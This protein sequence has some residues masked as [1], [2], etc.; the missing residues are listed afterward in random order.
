MLGAQI[1]TT[2]AATFVAWAA[3][4]RS[5][6]IAALFGGIVAVVPTAWFAIKT[7]PRPG[8]FKPVEILGATYRA[9]VGKLVLTASLFWIGAVLFRTQFAPLMLTCIACLSMNWLML[10]IA[11]FD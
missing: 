6:A 1:A 2:V 11:R 9:E 8:R 7:Y 5:A 10:A 4:G 3:R